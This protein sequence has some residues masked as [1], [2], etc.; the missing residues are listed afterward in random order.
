MTC[1]LTLFYSFSYTYSQRFLSIPKIT[2]QV[3]LLLTF[4]IDRLTFSRQP[5]LAWFD[6]WFSLANLT[7]SLIKQNGKKQK[8]RRQKTWHIFAPEPKGKVFLITAS[9]VDKQEQLGL[10]LE[11]RV[12]FNQTEKCKY[13]QSLA[14]GSR[15]PHTEHH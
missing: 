9:R 11:R 13:C 10:Q 4:S 7:N 2:S 15:N 14:W 6:K 5:S 12:T 1:C 3:A 8:R